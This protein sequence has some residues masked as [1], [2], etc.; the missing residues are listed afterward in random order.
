M[1]TSYAC[2]VCFLSIVS[3][4][5]SAVAEEKLRWAELPPLPNEL[6]VAGPFV[7]VHTTEQHDVLIIAGGANFPRPVWDNQKQWLNEIHV[8]EKQGGKYHWH[9]GGQL[10]RAIAYGAS[11]S[12][13]DGVVCIGGNDAANVYRDVF[14]LRWDGEKIQR[15][16]LPDLPEAVAFS[17]AAMIDNVVY[18]VGG[19]TGSGLDSATDKLWSLDLS[20]TE[21]G[22]RVQWKTLKPLP[23]KTRALHMVAAQRN[24]ES[25]CLYAIGGRRENDRQEVEFL[26][27]VWE[28]HPSKQRWRERR[29]APVVMMAGTAIGVGQSHI[30]VPGAAD[31]KDFYRVEELKD[32]HPGFPKKA[33][34]YNTLSD[35]WAAA[36][37]T[38]LTQVTTIPA[39]WHGEIIVPTGEIRPRVRTPKIFR[40]KPLP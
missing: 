12:T 40:V 13:A 15:K 18:L 6:G 34:V 14:R 7:G 28:Y 22:D 32:R 23:G 37:D 2:T 27:D 9:N 10:P 31:S 38:P 8:L 26:R 19:Q 4:A 39:L 11:V 1:K 25:S 30:Y 33:Y 36:G 21:N 17:Q 24:G 35:T 16:K 29:S 5:A 20:Q 3:F